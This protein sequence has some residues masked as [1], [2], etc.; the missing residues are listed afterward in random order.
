MARMRMFFIFPSYHAIPSNFFTLFHLIPAST[1][2]F[3]LYKHADHVTFSFPLILTLSF[4]SF[5]F[6]F[7][8]PSLFLVHSGFSDNFLTKKPRKE[9]GT[10]TCCLPVP[11]SP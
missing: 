5:L 11:P 9:G 4:V 10:L 3:P 8:N 6:V 1:F 7:L 2:F